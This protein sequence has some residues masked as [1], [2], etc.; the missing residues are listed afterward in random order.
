MK[1]F[2]ISS[3]KLFGY[4]RELGEKA[5]AQVP[6]DQW[7]WSPDEHSNSLAIL[8][9]HLAGNMRSRWT[10]FLESDGE[11]PWRDRDS[12][13]E[14]KYET[15][16]ELMA[17][18]NEGW[19][20]VETEMAKLEESDLEKVVYIRNQGHSVVEAIQRQIGHI[21]YHVGQMVSLGKL[22]LGENWKS[23]SIPKGESEEF[24]K[25]MFD[26]EKSRGHFTEKE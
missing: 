25:D 17:F 20:C 18:W 16:T 21:S 8:I 13:F 14:L 3:R 1:D 10:D 11:K 12:E 7:F 15:A 23:L 22:I 9:Q 6:E 2:I 4:Y 5:L 26:K 19:K 24:N